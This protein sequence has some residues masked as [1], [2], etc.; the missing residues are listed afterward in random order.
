LLERDTHLKGEKQPGLTESVHYCAIDL[1]YEC[2]E[3]L[4]LNYSGEEGGRS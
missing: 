1:L 4:F 2:Q 3:K